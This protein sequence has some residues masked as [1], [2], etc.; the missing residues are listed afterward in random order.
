MLNLIETY[1]L[2]DVTEHVKSCAFTIYFL[3]SPPPR[4]SH[5]P[6]SMHLPI[7]VIS[8]IAGWFVVGW[9][10]VGVGALI[11]KFNIRAGSIQINLP[12]ATELGIHNKIA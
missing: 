3:L 7:I 8:T 4:Y 10:W 5:Y 6:P 11:V 9:N 2:L 12:T 1:C